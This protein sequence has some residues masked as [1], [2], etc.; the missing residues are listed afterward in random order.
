MANRASKL[1]FVAI[2]GEIWGPLTNLSK[3]HSKFCKRWSA[4]V[5]LQLLSSNSCV[6][7][8]ESPH[9][10]DDVLA[11][12]FH[13]FGNVLVRVSAWQ[14]FF[15]LEWVK[16]KSLPVWFGLPQLPFEFMDP[17]VLKSIGDNFGN[18][19][20]SKFVFEEGKVLVKICVLVS[21]SSVC[22][23]SCK[24][25]SNDGI[26]RQPI[27]KMDDDLCQNLIIVDAPLFFD[28]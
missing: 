9:S 19:L 17:E 20:T 16:P 14:P 1:H 25:K 3:L 28:F 2:L 21:P 5:Y 8:F 12:S 10:K 7:V 6:L 23:I 24:I 13:W 27:V 22:P 18:F 11:N 4:L 15:V 26:W